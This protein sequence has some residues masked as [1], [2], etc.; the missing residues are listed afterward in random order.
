MR[1]TPFPYHVYI[2]K[3]LDGSFY[4]GITNDLE[5]RLQQ[6]N[7]EKL[8]GARYTR[9]RRPVE[10]VYIEKYPNRS[11]ACKREWYIKHMMNHNEKAEL[12]NKA[13]KEDILKAI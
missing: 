7:G 5:K 12:I 2:V 8:G 11:E 6:H 4:T 13:T 3:C 9:T 1:F 10:F